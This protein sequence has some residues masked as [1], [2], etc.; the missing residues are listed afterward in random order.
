MN[1]PTDC[2]HNIG[3]YCQIS[4]DLAQM[5][6]PI[7]Q[8]ACAACVLQPNPRTKNAVTCSKAIQ[9]Q[10]LVGMLPTEELLECVKPPSRGV[11]TEL[12]ILI[13]KTRS[14]L[15]RVWLG[16]LIPPRVQCGCSATRSYMNQ[17]GIHGCLRNRDHL[18][19]EILARWKKHL[20][21]IR[22]I[23]FSRFMVGVYITRAIQRFHN[24][25]TAHG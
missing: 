15:Q 4:T 12:E 24:K 9:Y 19:D 13:E 21:A 16:W 11:G 25:E 2:P 8:D 6:V 1:D 20:P 10:T 17:Q 23:P 22:F 5:P 14:L 3:G 18:A 7:A